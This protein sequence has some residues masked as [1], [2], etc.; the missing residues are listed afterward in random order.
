LVFTGDFF[1]SSEYMRGHEIGH[2]DRK[3]LQP[4]GAVAPE[5]AKEYT[6]FFLLSLFSTKF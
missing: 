4:D 1:A 3:K 6:L 5:T 2:G